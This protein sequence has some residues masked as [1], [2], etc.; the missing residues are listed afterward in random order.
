MVIKHSGLALFGGAP[1][2]KTPWPETNTIG[3][4]KN[5]P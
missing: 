3:D 2:A 5:V 1:V 4:E